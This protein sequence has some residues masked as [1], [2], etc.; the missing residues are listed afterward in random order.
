MIKVNI[1]SDDKTWRKYLKN[2]TSFVEKKIRKFNKK[3][4]K[5]QKNII[6]HTLLLSGEREIKR[7]N[8]RFRKKNK[9]TDVLSFPFY[10]NLELKKKLKHEKEVYLGDIIINLNKVNGKNDKSKFELEFIRL[11]IHGLVHLFGYDHK[12]I[13]EFSKMSKIEKKFISYL[14]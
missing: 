2:P 8:K 6:S 4:K 13:Q 10:K 1:I 3:F 9:P 14:N 12:R 5:Y 7:L 11:W